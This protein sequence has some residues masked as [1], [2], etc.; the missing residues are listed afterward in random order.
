MISKLKVETIKNII[1][2]LLL[3]SVVTLLCT[4]FRL[5]IERDAALEQIHPR[6][7]RRFIPRIPREYERAKD[8]IPMPVVP[9]AELLAPAE[10]LNMASIFPELFTDEE[11]VNLLIQ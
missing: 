2:G 11:I 8:V 1:I 4:C 9:D 5:M 7:E 6:E 10:Y 3:G